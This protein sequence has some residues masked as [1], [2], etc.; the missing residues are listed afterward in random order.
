LRSLGLS[1]LTP[2]GSTAF[3]A[4]RDVDGTL[5]AYGYRSRIYV[6]DPARW[7]I[8]FLQT[9]RMAPAQMLPKCA[10]TRAASG[11]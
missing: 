10:P 6:I 7:P 5:P 4:R 3:A 8:Y 9:Q 1:A 11:S 2:G